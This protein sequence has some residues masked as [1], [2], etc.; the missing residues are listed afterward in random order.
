MG[1]AGKE[2]VEDVTDIGDIGVADGAKS[3]RRALD[4]T[5]SR[6]AW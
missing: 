4:A 1:I 5:L 2:K 3:L 6:C